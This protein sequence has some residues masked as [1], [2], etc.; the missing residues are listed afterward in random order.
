M[1]LN[2]AGT[3]FDA[4]TQ[5]KMIQNVLHEGVFNVE[6]TKLNGELR[7]MP[8]TLHKDWMPSEAIR[9]HHQTRLYDPE[10]IS[11]W[12]TEKQAWR[13]FKTMRVITIKE[14]KNEQ[15]LDT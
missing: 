12:C 9:E 8:C 10:T 11:V 1:D 4:D 15:E 14:C 5:Y 7:V 13:S 2:F 6:F 3:S